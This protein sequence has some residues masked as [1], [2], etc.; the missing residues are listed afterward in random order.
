MTIRPGSRFTS[1]LAV[2]INLGYQKLNYL[3]NKPLPT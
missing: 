1:A 3:L 2:F